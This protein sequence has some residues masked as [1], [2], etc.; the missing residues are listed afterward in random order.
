MSV[1]DEVT[2]D[3]IIGLEIQVWI[4][5]LEGAQ[6]GAA[7]NELELIASGTPF[8]R[9]GRLYRRLRGNYIQAHFIRSSD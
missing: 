3:E 6:M 9:S 7:L 5:N 1:L 4:V 2:S 8:A